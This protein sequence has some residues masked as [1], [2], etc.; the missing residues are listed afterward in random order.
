MTI[1][2]RPVLIALPFALAL[3]GCIS[4]GGKPPESLL[5]LSP[6]ASAPAGPGVPTGANR[7]VIAATVAA[8]VAAVIVGAAATVAVAVVTAAGA[9]ATAARPVCPTS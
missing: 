2:L 7:A 3:T 9:N 4:L 1:R 8:R 5:T 6:A